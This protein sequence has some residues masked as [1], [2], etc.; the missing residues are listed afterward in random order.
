LLDKRPLFAYTERVKGREGKQ[1]PSSSVSE[2][3]RLVRGRSG[4]RA[5]SSPSRGAERSVG[6]AV[7]PR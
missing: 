4:D 1:Y 6:A 3:G 2:S 5:K 7:L